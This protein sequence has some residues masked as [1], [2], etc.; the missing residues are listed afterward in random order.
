MS[1]EV[2]LFSKS[3]FEIEGIKQWAKSG[4]VAYAEYDKNQELN[5]EKMATEFSEEIKNSFLRFAYGENME[6][7]ELSPAF[8]E[9]FGRA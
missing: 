7:K 1:K 8:I 6:K 9:I 5:V 4:F 3:I 2:L